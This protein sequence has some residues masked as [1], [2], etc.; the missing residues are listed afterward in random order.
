MK[1]RLLIS[2]IVIMA[3]LFMLS[4]LAEVVEIEKDISITKSAEPLFFSEIGQEIE[5]EILIENTG[6]INLDQVRVIDELLG[7][8]ELIGSMAPG[9]E[10]VITATYMITAEDMEREYVENTASVT[11]DDPNFIGKGSGSKVSAQDSNIIEADVDY[12]PAIS[13]TK[14]ASPTT[15][16]AVGDVIDYTI[17]VTNT[18]NVT[19][20]DV[21]VTDS[22]IELGIGAN[23]GTLEPGEETTVSG[24]YT[25]VQADLD[26]GSVLNTAEVAGQDPEGTVVED[27]DD[28]EVTSEM[29][30][31]IA[32]SKTAD[33]ITYSAVGDV[34]SY[35]ITVTN[36]G[37]MTL[38]N[39]MVTDSKIELGAGANIG[40]L[41]PGEETT[42]S[43]SYTIVQADLDNGS[44]L[45]TAEVTS[46]DSQGTVVGDSSNTVEVDFEY[47]QPITEVVNLGRAIDFVILSYAGITNV[48]TSDITGDIGVSPIDSTAITAFSLIMD[49]SNE[50]AISDQVDGKVYAA[51]YAD[52]TPAILTQA[53][54]DM[55]AAYTDAAGRV[56]DYI[57]LYD[58]LLGGK[59]LEPGVYKWNSNVLIN[60]DIT[61]NGSETD[62]WIF[63]ITGQLIQTNNT[64]INLT[65]GAQAENIFWQVA[66]TV[67]IGSGASFE[68][69]I[70]GWK[71]I[72]MGAG[73][74]VNGRLFALTENVTLIQNVITEP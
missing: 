18:G 11:G 28:A 72:T 53:V 42:V 23:I 64:V 1:K 16:S 15:Y 62:V 52:P 31:D 66:D 10:Q 24:S 22:K 20:S 51:D 58:G 6:N 33:P 37:N 46:E 36:T 70:L 13:L 4:P 8:D 34:I 21:M 7:I 50:F 43:G 74:S 54:N 48:P 41:E 69:I 73:A 25:I 67:S 57:D 3:M 32:L 63:Q 29:N 71:D 49:P 68:G 5:Y 55:N 14:E 39:V 19:L 2:F 26:N 56:A 17:T 44:V 9:E 38:S 65:G 59:I 40:T 45:N 60:D 12:Q 27:F 61:L 47:I 30:P 35:T